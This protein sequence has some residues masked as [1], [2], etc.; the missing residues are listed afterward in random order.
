MQG[1]DEAG[2][3]AYSGHLQKD[4]LRPNVSSGKRPQE[5]AGA[6]S[7]EDMDA[8]ET[9]DPSPAPEDAARRCAHRSRKSIQACPGSILNQVML[10]VIEE[11]IR[12]EKLAK[13]WRMHYAQNHG[14]AVL[15][16]Y[17]QGFLS[18]GA[19]LAAIWVRRHL[20]TSSGCRWAIEQLSGGPM[21]TKGSP[22]TRLATLHFLARQ[23]FFA[24]EAAPQVST[25]T[26]EHLPSNHRTFQTWENLSE[27]SK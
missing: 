9:E 19:I 7:D 13:L 3:Q 2:L 23:A 27:L 11:L 21:L 5:D 6:G 24:D 20:K 8:G 4:F 22:A 25:Y 12:M 14:K 17:K 16:C 1:L 15:H 18:I 26:Y 10:T